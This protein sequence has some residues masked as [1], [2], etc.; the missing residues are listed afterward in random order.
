MDRLVTYL[1]DNSSPSSTPQPVLPNDDTLLDAYSS[2]V[3]SA[4]AKVAPA[5]VAIRTQAVQSNRLR[6]LGTGSGFFFTPDG[7]LLTNSHVIAGASIVTVR[8]PASDASPTP[9]DLTAT[10]IG[11]DPDTDLAILR[12]EG[13]PYPHVDFA[14]ATALRPGQLAIAIGNPLGFQATVTAGV[15][16][17]LGRSMRA[18]TG[19][20]IDNVVQTDAALNPGNSGGPLVNSAGKL[21]GVNTAVIM[22]AQGICFAT[23]V[24]TVK[25]VLPHLLSHGRLRRAYLGIAGQNLPPDRRRQRALNL[26]TD[27][28]IL[29][30]SIEPNS[31]AAAAR[32]VEGDVLLALADR[33]LASIDDLHRALTHDQ[34]EIPQLLTILRG[35]RT[36]TLT[37]TPA[38]ASPTRARAHP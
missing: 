14:D 10:V 1:S 18:S 22:G 37:I 19:R 12:V 28:G 8:L 16:S 27:A 4:V 29:V 24:S 15:V 11:D 5:V 36:Q 23:G 3:T 20:L 32:L 21:I 34:I 31:P 17:A 2:A 13:G 35:A 30:M 7:F 38:D 25:F 9:R 26:P 6:T 33:P